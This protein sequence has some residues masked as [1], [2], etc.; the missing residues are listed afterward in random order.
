MARI[1]PL[2]GFLLLIPSVLLNAYFVKSHLDAKW[3]EVYKVTD[4][5][6]FE[7]KDFKTIRLLGVFAPELEACGG[8]QA[9]KELENLISGKKIAFD[10]VLTDS[11]KRTIADVSLPS[12][13]SVNLAMIKSGWAYYQSGSTSH[14]WQEMRTAGDQNREA[15]KGIY[16]QECTQMV[17]TKNPTCDI[18]GNVNQNGGKVYY[19]PK[20]PRYTAISVEL[21]RQDQWFCSEKEAQTA[22]FVKGESCP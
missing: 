3:H 18:K 1:I 19:G 21:Y 11:Y 5:D 12:G 10:S 6:T 22:G 16:S 8:P 20:C 2:L 14:N 7:T 4:G 17:N 13:E 9:K 15:K